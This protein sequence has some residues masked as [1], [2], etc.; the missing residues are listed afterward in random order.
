MQVLDPVTVARVLAWVCVAGLASTV[1]LVLAA[2]R[3]G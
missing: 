2:W 3:S 1:G